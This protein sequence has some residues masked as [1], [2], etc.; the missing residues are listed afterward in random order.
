MGTVDASR[1]GSLDDHWT[2]KPDHP[3]GRSMWIPNWSNASVV[4][5]GG[6]ISSRASS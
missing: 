5:G 4:S 2:R 1:N 3:A 6:G